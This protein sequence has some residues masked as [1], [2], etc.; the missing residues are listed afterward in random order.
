[1]CFQIRSG[2]NL[3]Y[4]TRCPDLNITRSPSVSIAQTRAVAFELRP[5]K[6]SSRCRATLDKDAEAST[7]YN[8]EEGRMEK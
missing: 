3:S 6:D 7:I 1:M 4:N 2:P 5:H 8:A